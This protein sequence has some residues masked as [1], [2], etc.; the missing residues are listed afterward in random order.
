MDII[1][2]LTQPFTYTFMQHALIEVIVIAILT[3]SV[4]TF[5]VLKNLAFIGEALSHAVFPGVVVA[6]LLKLNII[7]GAL[8]AGILAAFG[9]SILSEQK[10]ISDN[11][12]TGILF[13][14]AFALGVVLISSIKNFKTDL[15]SFLIGN[16]LGVTEQDILITI[17]VAVIVIVSLVFFY[18]ELY[19]T[20]FDKTFARALGIK[21][22][23]INNLF[24]ILIALTIVASIQAVGNVLVVALL[25]I[26]PA[27]ARIISKTVPQMLFRSVVISLVCG[28]VGLY[29]S[30]YANTAAGATIVLT[31]SVVFFV[32]LSLSNTKKYLQNRN[33]Y[34]VTSPA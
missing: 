9:I 29:I 5:L 18:R 34:S 19:I 25:V 28:L 17:F 7:L 15:A 6:F 22:E 3:G 8:V 24:F 16:I 14:S 27:T 13:S 11:T 33:V 30:F 20:T 4:G 10:E 12:A 23:R 21:V 31:S 1:A 32:V 26:T 2:F